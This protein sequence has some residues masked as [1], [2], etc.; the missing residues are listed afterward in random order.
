[1][2]KSAEIEII[3][4][5]K[6]LL[7]TSSVATLATILPKADEIG[8]SWPYASLVLM[9]TAFDGSPLL[10]LSELAEHTKNIHETML[11]VGKADLAFRLTMQVRNKMVEAYQEVMRMQV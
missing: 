11:A 9:A 3:A 5:A 7:R 8:V 4:E 6:K 10:L 1:M 2:A